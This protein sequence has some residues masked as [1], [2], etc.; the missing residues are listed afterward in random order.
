M[1]VSLSNYK[2]ALAK[3]LLKKA[4][5]CTVRECDETAKGHYEGY[6]DEGAESYDVAL[7]IASGKDITAHRCDCGQSTPFCQHKAALL[8]AIA[9]GKKAAQTVM[10]KKGKAKQSKTDALQDEAN[11]DEL[12]EWVRMLLAKNNDLA[13]A[14]VQ[15]FGERKTVHTKAEAEAITADATKSVVKN[16]TRVEQSELKKIVD[17]WGEVHEPIVQAHAGNVTSEEA[18]TAFH[19]VLDACLRFAEKVAAT[20]TKIANYVDGLLKR[21]VE[22]IAVL[23]D[24]EA[25]ESATGFYMGHIPDG[26][27]N[28]RLHMFSTCKMYWH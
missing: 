12:K 11:A 16:R 15:R 19:S 2:T 21:M 8:L 23:H 24:D 13:L 4:A 17:L 1:N 6:V 18:F 5:A 14:F 22:P 20:G 26:V 10:V 9:E 28:L 3:P 27:R 7:T 25:F